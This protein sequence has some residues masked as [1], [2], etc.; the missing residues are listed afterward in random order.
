MSKI[1]RQYG[2]WD[3]P[4]D[5][6][7]VA[8]V[9]SSYSFPQYDGDDIYAIKYIPKEGRKV[10][11]RFRSGRSEEEIITP[12]GYD[13]KS[14]VHE[15]GGLSYAVK[16]SVVYFVNKKDQQIYKQEGHRIT[17]LTKR[18]RSRYADFCLDREGNYL[19]CVRETHFKYKE[20]K[21]EIVRV[22]TQDGK[23]EV[24]F[25]GCDFYAWPRI[26]ESGRK[27]AFI[28]WRH[29]HMPWDESELYISETGRSGRFKKPIKIAGGKQTAVNE[30]LWIGKHL[31][32]T[33]DRDN[34]FQIYRI[35][36][37]K[38]GKPEKLTNLQ[39]EFSDVLFVFGWRRYGF[40]GRDK[41]FTAVR[42]AEGQ[43]CWLIDLKTKK[44]SRLDLHLTN[45]IYI[46]TSEDKVLFIG[47]SFTRDYTL[48]EYNIKTK[49]LRYIK[50]G[51]V[52][53]DRA[54][55]ST[56]KR[57]IYT[58]S[59]G[60]T[61]YANYY[62]PKNKK[63]RGKGL[64]PVVVFTHGGPTASCSQSF[65]IRVQYFTSRG[66]AVLDVDYRGS[67]GYGREY[68][69]KLRGRWGRVDVDD[70]VFGVLYLHYN[71]LADITRAF[72]RGGSAGGY[73]TL[74]ALTFTSMFRAGV[75][76]FGVSDLQLLAEQTHKFESHYLDVLIGKY[77]EEKK[78]YIK[79]SPVYNI[80]FIETPILFLQGDE[81]KIVPPNQ[82][83]K[84]YQALKRKGIRT[85]YILF[86]GEAHGFVK[87]NNIIRSLKEELKF[88]QESLK[89][90][91]INE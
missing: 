74:M 38:S 20:P 69:D 6:E 17:K 76:Y 58:T 18:E 40:V 19:Y 39:A 90:D 13:V 56:P 10:V 77:P 87:R 15:Y 26:D 70:C 43:S 60:D 61:A 27:I 24:L 44:A 71:K 14:R 50:G 9:S 46:H 22:G 30:P 85:K 68:R 62:P 82:A 8:E 3:S 1:I 45:F 78:K 33:W 79:L 28:C 67:Y 42:S 57:I 11:V 55:I 59:G 83:E 37:F 84:M 34:W 53:L 29:P 65:N 41:V 7:K 86:K 63:F 64:P 12:K 89:Q 5:E 72:I 75:S 51:D 73:T 2:F 49:K 35:R 52:D 54:Y 21:N 48:C 80:E 91:N 66:F 32:F 31:Y 36:N 23:E 47:A 4:V 16:D 25:S 88:Y 81:D